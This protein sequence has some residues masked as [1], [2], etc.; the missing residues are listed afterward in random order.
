MKT[1]W[2]Q[3]E[4]IQKLIRQINWRITTLQTLKGGTFIM[5]KKVFRLMLNEHPELRDELDILEGRKNTLE[6]LLWKL[7]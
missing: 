6:R 7:P 4:Q 5:T 1:K 2:E 3:K